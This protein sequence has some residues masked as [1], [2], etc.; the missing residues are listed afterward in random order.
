MVKLETGKQWWHVCQALVHLLLVKRRSHQLRVCWRISR[1]WIKV[2]KFI[3]TLNSKGHLARYRCL[4]VLKYICAYHCRR[5]HRRLLL[6]QFFSPWCSL[7]SLKTTKIHL[8]WWNHKEKATC[9]KKTALH[10]PTKPHSPVYKFLLIPRA[11]KSFNPLRGPNTS[12][13]HYSFRYHPSWVQST[14]QM[15]LHRRV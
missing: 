4:S 12:K 13:P 3:P 7:L 15:S 9:S 2:A 8:M 10:Q 11:S 6:N 5:H 14:G 1:Y